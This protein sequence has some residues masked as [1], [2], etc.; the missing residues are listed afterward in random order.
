MQ[1]KSI[2]ILIFIERRVLIRH[3]ISDEINYRRTN[4]ERRAASG[5]FWI[6]TAVVV[7][8]SGAGACMQTCPGKVGSDS[9]FENLSWCGCTRLTNRWM[10]SYLTNEMRVCWFSVI[11]EKLILF[12]CDFPEL[13]NC[14]LLG[15]PQDFTDSRTTLL[16]EKS[17]KIVIY[18]CYYL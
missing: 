18:S 6:E 10:L 4:V 2:T 8:V 15:H 17:D 1:T 9:F 13:Y 12:V 14:Y 3:R 7:F 5:L 16:A 11:E